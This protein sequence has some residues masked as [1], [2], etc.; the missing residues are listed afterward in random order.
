MRGP[1]FANTYFEGNDC[2]VPGSTPY[3]IK[4][5]CY[6]TVANL[7]AAI[8]HTGDN[9]LYT[10]NAT[11]SESCGT[12]VADSHEAWQAAG[13]DPGTAV[14]EWPSPKRVLA[15]GKRRLGL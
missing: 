12:V 1:L 11:F 3:S 10:Y 14:H 15:M 4:K 7:S 6:A 9:N 5:P 2:I 8:F 13:Q